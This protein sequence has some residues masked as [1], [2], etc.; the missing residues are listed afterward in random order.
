VRHF[1]IGQKEK[2]KGGKKKKK[3]GFPRCLVYLEYKEKKKSAKKGVVMIS[4]R[5]GRKGKERS[6]KR[7]ATLTAC[8]ESAQK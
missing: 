3:D 2:R 8:K 6:N 5:P 1:V 7:T 4:I